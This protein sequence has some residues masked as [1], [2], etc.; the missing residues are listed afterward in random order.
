MLGIKLMATGKLP[1]NNNK[2]KIS[3]FLLI[4]LFGLT[5]IFLSE[6]ILFLCSRYV[7]ELYDFVQRA[8][9]P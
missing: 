8:L 7:F 6:N 5:S 2:K 3:Q 4:I 1:S 9:Q